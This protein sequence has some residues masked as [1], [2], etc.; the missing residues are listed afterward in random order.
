MKNA[1]LISEFIKKNSPWVGLEPT[2]SCEE[3]EGL[4]SAN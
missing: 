2:K 3:L 1:H 4:N